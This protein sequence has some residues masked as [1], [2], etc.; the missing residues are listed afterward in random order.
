MLRIENTRFFLSECLCNL[1]SKPEILFV[2]LS[3][4]KRKGSFVYKF[5]YVI[6]ETEL[7]SLGKTHSVKNHFIKNHNDDQK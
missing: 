3:N 1:N 4:G 2:S 6:F 5:L 7:S